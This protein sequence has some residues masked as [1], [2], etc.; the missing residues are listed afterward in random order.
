[1][2]V[3]G[4]DTAE[5][6]SNEFGGEVF[7]R[8]Y[9]TPTSQ[10][11]LFAEVNAGFGTEKTE[12][13]ANV[14]TK[15]NKFGVHAGLGLSYFLS[16]NFAIEASWAGLGYDSRKLDA[17]GADAKNTFGLNVDLRSFGFGVVYKF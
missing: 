10:F 7:G 11:S 8:Y 4:E 15:Y 13:V 14:E 12:T 5:T 3:S 16:N 17:T 1:M 9:V 6:K 2:V